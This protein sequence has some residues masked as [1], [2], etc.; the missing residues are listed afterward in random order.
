MSKTLEKRFYDFR[1]TVE[2]LR[3]RHGFESSYFIPL[4]EELGCVP[5]NRWHFRILS[6]LDFCLQM[7]AYMGVDVEAPV[8]AA[9]SVLEKA[10]QTDGAVPDSVCKEAEDC[11]LPLK[12]EAKAYKL[13]LAGHAHIDMNWKWS[14]DE[15]VSTTVNTFKTMLKLMEEYPDFHFSQSQ[16]STYKIIEDYAPWMMDEIKKRIKEGRWEVNASSWVETDKNMPSIDSLLN[17]IYYAKKYMH[18][19]WDIDPD[20]LELEFAP[21]TFGHSANVPEICN[22]AGMKYYY[23]CRGVQDPELYLYRW[24][25]PSGKEVLAYKEP[26]WYSA[27]LY[28]VSAIGLPRAAAAM[29]GFKTGL[30]PYGVGD[31]GGGP[32]R[33]DLNRALWMMEWPIFPELRFGTFREFFKEA[34]TIRDTLRVIEGELNPIFTGCYTTQSRIKRGNRRAETAL[35]N[36]EK[37][38]AMASFNVGT[39]YLE[40]AFEEGWRD[41]LFTHF[42]DILT[43]SCVQDSREHAM[44]IYQNVIGRA[45]TL[46]AHSLEELAA[47]IDTSA[48]TSDIDATS[49]SMGAGAGYGMYEGNIPTHESNCGMNRIYTIVNTENAERYETAKITVWDWQGSINLPEFVDENG[50]VLES[51]RISGYKIF[52][53]HR[54]FEM[55][56]TV[57]VPAL[58]YTTVMLREKSPEIETDSFVNARQDYHE[59]LPFSDIVLENDYIKASFDSVTAEL[60]S[61]IDKKSGKERIRS[62]ETAGLRLITAEKNNES[63]WII[64]RWI[65]NE[66]LYDLKSF[67]S[68]AGNLLSGLTTEHNL[69]GSVIKTKITLGKYDKFLKVSL[70]IDWKGESKD[71]SEQPVLYYAIPL[72]DSDGRVLADVPGGAVWR[73]DREIDMPS[74]RYAAAS[75]SDG[76]VLALASDCKYG[77]RLAKGNLYCTLINV[78]EHPDP[79]P[80]RGIHEIS[81]FILP[82]DPVVSALRRKTDICL[83]PLQNVA[84]TLH[85]GAMP[86]NGSF[87]DVMSDSVVLSS[88]QERSGRTALRFFEADGKRSAVTV[89]FKKAVTSAEICDIFGKR[90]DVEVSVSGDTVTFFVEPYTEAE[91]RVTK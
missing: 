83:N 14:W 21:D 11:L 71:R 36:G 82:A 12:E 65:K 37:F 57:K 75:L 54:Y 32:T 77:F 31:H 80:E 33:R 78:A 34:E 5:V 89:K 22:M 6:E 53:Q 43:G 24:R 68:F 25:A 49:R 28:A 51:E 91:L 67:E 79:Y 50:T 88:I 64:G 44:G 2:G 20:S 60:Y 58:G 16:A 9:L 27:G 26:Y 1:R 86:A 90:L 39:P 7:K 29:N 4:E 63:S 62:G 3:I 41:A 40:K 15:T 66:K 42:H 45:N 55:L 10:V 17:Q 56:V 46:A 72:E 30:M 48:F 61:L 8:S 73:D 76:R 84:N 13:I 35:L 23:H 38:A 87:V 47:A 18:E 69:D 81:L 85:G 70:E 59:H 74:Q 52:W 19:H